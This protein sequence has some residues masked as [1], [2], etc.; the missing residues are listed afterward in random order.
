MLIMLLAHFSN[1]H[2]ALNLCLR[3]KS[4]SVTSK[5]REK[6]ERSSTKKKRSCRKS[7]TR[8]LLTSICSNRRTCSRD[9]RMTTDLSCHLP[10]CV[11]PH[12]PALSTLLI[13]LVVWLNNMATVPDCNSL[14]MFIVTQ[15]DYMWL[16]RMASGHNR[17]CCDLSDNAFTSSIRAVIVTVCVAAKCLCTLFCVLNKVF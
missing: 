2:P 12:L 9:T 3:R 7:W 15:Q 14:D 11:V 16:V 13:R 17:K 6:H 5:L 8:R 10:V 1:E 4:T